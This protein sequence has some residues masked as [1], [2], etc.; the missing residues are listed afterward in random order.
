MGSSAGDKSEPAIG[1]ALRGPEVLIIT[2]PAATMR[3]VALIHAMVS[4]RS[5]L[6]TLWLILVLRSYIHI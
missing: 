5:R 2:T 3:I 4:S 1:V 6:A